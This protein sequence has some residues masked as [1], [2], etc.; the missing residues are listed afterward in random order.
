MFLF[1]LVVLTT[2]FMVTST[3][4]LDVNS[5]LTGGISDTKIIGG[6]GRAS[7]IRTWPVSVQVV[8]PGYHD[9]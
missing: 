2:Q 1:I 9:N 7:C 8:A 3:I 5:K 4:T 6:T